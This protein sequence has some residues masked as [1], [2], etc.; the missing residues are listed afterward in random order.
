MKR[1][2]I[3]V[4]TPRGSTSGGFTLVEAAITLAIVALVLVTILQGMEGAKLTA[5]HTRQKKI[6]YELG[7]GLLGEVSVGLWREDLESGMTGDFAEQ[8]E[9][10][11][12]WE[13]ALGEDVFDEQQSDDQDRPFDNFAAR[14]DWEEDNRSETEENEL[15]DGEEP[16]EPFEKVR[17]RITFAKVRNFPNEMILESWVPWE[18]IYGPSEEDEDFGSETGEAGPGNEATAAA[19]PGETAAPG[20]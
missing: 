20:R 8:D 19:A 12:F 15:E 4:R 17:V 10:N 18:D 16:V 7:V 5:F 14:R 2:P 9:E 1:P 3:Q 11:F 6:A 13:L